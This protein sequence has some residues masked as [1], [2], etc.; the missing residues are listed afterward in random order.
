VSRSRLDLLEIDLDGVMSPAP[1][2]IVVL[3]FV[4]DDLAG[5]P[6]CAAACSRALKNNSSVMTSQR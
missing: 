4:T 2:M 3:S 5:R 6:S 1:S